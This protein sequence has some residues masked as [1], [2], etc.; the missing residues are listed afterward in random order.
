[1]KIDGHHDKDHPSPS[2]SDAGTGDEQDFLDE[3][4]AER[5][6]QN[7]EFPAMVRKAEEARRRMRLR[8]ATPE[9]K[10]RGLGELPRDRE[11]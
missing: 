5:A 6:R 10:R 3:L 1:M 8:R 4:I 2:G 11:G 9:E 7:P